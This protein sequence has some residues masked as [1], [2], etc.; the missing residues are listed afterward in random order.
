MNWNVVFGL[1]VLFCFFG[2]PIIL[3]TW[4]ANKKTKQYLYALTQL[5]EKFNLVVD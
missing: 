1:F 4:F 3:W 2:L 5:A